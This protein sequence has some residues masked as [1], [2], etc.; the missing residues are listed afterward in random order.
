MN[1]S[2][3]KLNDVPFGEIAEAS[4]SASLNESPPLNRAT[5][6]EVNRYTTQRGFKVPSESDSADADRYELCV[7]E[8]T[9]TLAFEERDDEQ[10]DDD[11]DGHPSWLELAQRVGEEKFEKLMDELLS[12]HSNRI[13]RLSP[14][15]P[16]PGQ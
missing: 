3:A 11:S 6:D 4:H 7:E 2:Q 12:V 14:D 10:Y 5:T 15:S 13:N 1:A 8:L 16:Y 9:N